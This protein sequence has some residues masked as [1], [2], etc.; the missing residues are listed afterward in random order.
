M[1]RLDDILQTHDDSDWQHGQP[2]ARTHAVESALE[3]GHVLVFPELRFVLS[4]TERRFLDTRYADP[5][6]KNISL[7]GAQALMR[8]AVGTA[9]D[10]VEL[11]AMLIRFRDQAT[12]LAQ[13]LFPHYTGKLQ[14]A[15][16]SYRPIS[17]EGRETSWRKDDTRLHVDAFPSNPTQGARLL[18]IFTNVNPGNQPRVWRVGEDFQDFARTFL[19]RIKR[20]L[21]GSGW[22]LETLHVTKQRR[23]E[24][25]HLM[26]GLHDGAKADMAWQGSCPQREVAFA[27]GTTWVVFSD[28]V[29][30][31]VMSGQFMMEQTFWLAPADQQ[32][33]ETSPLRVLEQMTGRRLGLS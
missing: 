21:P 8:G 14:V 5:A 28:Q 6:T 11:R 20:P 26:L 10:L 19:P 1:A 17:V 12:A 3:T 22:L 23:T 4:E 29:L 30:H 16:T 2:G 15:N 27:P 13:R 9:E 31:A 33:P 24:F 32:H 18:R 25:D 7:R